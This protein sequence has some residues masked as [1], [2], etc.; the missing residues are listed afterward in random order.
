MRILKARRQGCSARGLHTAPCP[1][2]HPRGL[3]VT[4]GSTPRMLGRTAW[5]PQ[6]EGSK[7]APAEVTALDAERLE[8]PR[9][10]RNPCPAATTTAAAQGPLALA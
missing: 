8:A 9:Q 1:A 2:P 10:D 5:S 6:A 4:G 3:D 7:A